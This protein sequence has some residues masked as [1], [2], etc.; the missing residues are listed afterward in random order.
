MNL[1]IK[2]TGHAKEWIAPSGTIHAD[3]ELPITPKELVQKLG[4]KKGLVS[5]VIVGD[6]W[7]RWDE[8]ITRQLLKESGN[9]IVIITPVGGG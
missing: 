1:T 3:I 5:A 2:I 4:I 8:P 6:K 7:L 9:K